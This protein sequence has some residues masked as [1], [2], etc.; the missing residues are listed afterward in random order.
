[1]ARRRADDIHAALLDAGLV[2][3]RIELMSEV[4]TLDPMVSAAHRLSD[5]TIAGFKLLGVPRR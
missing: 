1:V 2:V 5:L 3:N 4:V